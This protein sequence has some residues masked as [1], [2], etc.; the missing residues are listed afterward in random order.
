MYV[1]ETG[2]LAVVPCKKD[3]PAP[4]RRSPRATAT[5]SFDLKVRKASA[6]DWE[7]VASHEAAAFRDTVTGC[8]IYLSETGAVAAVAEASEIDTHATLRTKRTK[9][10]A[11]ESNLDSCSITANHGLQAIYAS[12][13]TKRTVSPVCHTP[14]AGSEGLRA[15][16]FHC[17]CQIDTHPRDVPRHNVFLAEQK[18]F[19]AP[20]KSTHTVASAARHKVLL[21]ERK[22]FVAPDK[23]THTPY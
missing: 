13:K 9:G 5:Y 19:V 22:R 18:R 17:A 6:F 12:K 21:A 20:D 15:K 4:S 3:L 14:H 7:Q 2:G 11:P 1:S 10:P 8:L 23:S 16:A